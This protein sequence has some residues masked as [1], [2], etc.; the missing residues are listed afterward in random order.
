MIQDELSNVQ[1]DTLNAEF[2]RLSSEFDCN[3]FPT[4]NERK[5]VL[6]NLKQALIDNQV[7]FAEALAKDYGERSQFDS[8]MAD[9]MPTVQHINYTL[10]NLSRWLKPQRRH[11]GLMLLPSSLKI[12]KQPLGVV[13]II[14]PWNFPLFLSLGPLATAIAAGNRVM[15]K[16]SEY[17]PNTNQVLVRLLSEFS[18]WISVIEGGPQVAA[19]FTRLPFNH[20][21]F[22]GSTAVGKK[23]AL[24]CAAN[25]T[26]VTLEL[27]GKS[28]VVITKHA[29]L[30]HA[31]DSIL[32]AKT[33]NAGQICVAPDYLLI[34]K[35]MTQE[36]ITTY[37]SRFESLF[38]ARDWQGDYTAIV[39]QAQFNRLQT[40]LNDAK[41][42][43]A[44]VFTPND[45][46]IES[47]QRIMPPHLLTGVSDE[48]M[49]LQDEI[50]GPLLP[51]M[52]FDELD[53]A[54]AYIN[55][56]P[57]PLALYLM[58][59][60]K[61]E[62]QHVITQSHSGGVCINDTL[63]Q[64]AAEDVP[65]GGVGLS[66]MGQYHGVEGFNTFTHSKSILTT[67]TWLPRARLVLKYR[68]L[69]AKCLGWLFVR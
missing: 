40:M 3:K 55:S 13:G 61:Q 46:A 20:V 26:P 17:T 63:L 33:I 21:F 14:V 34:D 16:L 36:F 45:F 69:A 68:K 58:S 8:L 41:A 2:K 1:L 56:K 35:S 7:A 64:V 30:V 12:V 39:N 52:E 32:F 37:C 53:N 42:Q 60:N 29:N 43:G 27:G 59:N 23:V 15:L 6:L 65:F 54:L 25:L 67:P 38:N 4:I 50:F 48:M 19:S 62:Q 47:E 31:V 24:S 51:I 18:P 5:S 10:S 11:A 44:A 57:K 9:L 66:G 22:T 49:V 28:P